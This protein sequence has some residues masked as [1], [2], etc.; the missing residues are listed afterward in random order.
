VEIPRRLFKYQ[1]FS[2]LSVRGL[3]EQS[4]YFGAPSKFNDPY[5]CSFSLR[6]K[7]QSPE[8]LEAFREKELRRQDIP[9]HVKVELQ[10]MTQAEIALVLKRSVNAAFE[11]QT[12]D[13]RKNRGISC[14]S[15]TNENLL[16]WSHYTGGGSGFCLEF[17]TQ[18]QPF[19]KS[20]P[21]A[22]TK[23]VPEVDPLEILRRDAAKSVTV[24]L[25]TKSRHW[26]YEREWRV[27]HD[28][29]ETNFTYEAAAL[30][31]IYFG[32]EILPSSL[33]I[34]CLIIQ[35][36]NPNVKFFKAERSS[37]EYKL[38]FTEFHYTNYYAAKRNGLST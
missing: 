16:M 31:G 11:V 13:F 6:V 14:F 3:K 24:V 35:G 21:V 20:F 19:D 9:D 10:Q 7:E 28:K 8:Q 36:Q 4:I 2:E 34:I 38:V 17:D 27:I 29:A 22:Y 32:T 37:T 23:E 5:D 12:G 26:E 18:F 30:V 15:E 33:E 1:P 25:T